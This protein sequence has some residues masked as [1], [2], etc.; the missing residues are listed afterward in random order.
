GTT[1]NAVLTVVVPWTA[2]TLTHFTDAGAIWISAVTTPVSSWSAAE[3]PT[4]CAASKAIA[5]SLPL[6]VVP[7]WRRMF[8]ARPRAVIPKNLP[9]S[10]ANRPSPALGPTRRRGPLVGPNGTARA[11]PAHPGE[12]RARRRYDAL[13]GRRAARIDSRPRTEVLP[14]VHEHVDHA[15]P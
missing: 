12:P 11:K 15:R 7:S 13:G 5:S 1:L 9:P 2:F 10:R 4:S 3:H 8:R 6:I 14:E